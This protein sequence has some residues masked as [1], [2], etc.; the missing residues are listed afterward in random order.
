MK[1]NLNEQ[2]LPR[3]R[4]IILLNKYSIDDVKNYINGL[5]YKSRKTNETEICNYWNEVA[6]EV[7]KRI[8]GK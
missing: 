7:K 1:Y 8:Y 6:T 5:I 3:D 4:A 2:F